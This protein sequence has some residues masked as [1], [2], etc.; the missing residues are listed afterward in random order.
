MPVLAAQQ[1]EQQPQPVQDQQPAQEQSLVREDTEDNIPLISATNQGTSQQ[2]ASSVA[3]ES[4]SIDQGSESV[5]EFVI[6]SEAVRAIQGLQE[7]AKERMTEMEREFMESLS[8]IGQRLK[9]IN[10]VLS[11]NV[12]KDQGKSMSNNTPKLTIT[13]P[14]KYNGERRFDKLQEFV[15][16]IEKYYRNTKATYQQVVDTFHEHL[17]GEAKSWFKL[18]ERLKP[19]T[20]EEEWTLKAIVDDLLLYFKPLDSKESSYE[21]LKNWEMRG[22]NLSQF[23]TE[24]LSLAARVKL[25]T[26]NVTESEIVNRCREKLAHLEEGFIQEDD[27]IKDL[28]D[29][30]KVAYKFDRTLQSRRA[31]TNSAHKKHLKRSET[32]VS[33]QQPQQ[34][35]GGEDKA[36]KKGRRRLT[37]EEL[38]RYMKEDLCFKCGEPGHKSNDPVHHPKKGFQKE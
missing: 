15:A 10:L 30:V 8:D 4:E 14:K 33:V 23:I 28:M 7:T 12:S 38:E 25:E 18:R 19:M 32:S 21:R 31:N 26:K 20:F 36:E 22:N 6:N 2:N 1:Q 37:P 27:N 29:L 16:D 3:S 35:K 13:A 24:Y 11:R 5:D 34:E 17:S 9:F